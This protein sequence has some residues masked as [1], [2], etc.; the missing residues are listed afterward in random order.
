MIVLEQVQAIPDDERSLE[1]VSVAQSTDVSP[2]KTWRQNTEDLQN[3]VAEMDE[4]LEN[5]RESLTNIQSN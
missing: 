1:T 5:E 2:V 3:E 4:D